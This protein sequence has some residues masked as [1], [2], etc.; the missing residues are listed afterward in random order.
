M[1]LFQNL[2][3]KAETQLQSLEAAAKAD[4]NSVRTHLEAAL[5]LG[6]LHQALANAEARAAQEKATIEAEWHKVFG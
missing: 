5:H 4:V 2:V 3:S 1:S 6:A